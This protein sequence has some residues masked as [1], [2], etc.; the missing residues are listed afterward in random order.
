MDKPRKMQS[1]KYAADAHR[2]T[3]TWHIFTAQ[4]GEVCVLFGRAVQAVMAALRKPSRLYLLLPTPPAIFRP[5][6]GT[7]EVAQ[8]P[9]ELVAYVRKREREGGGGGSRRGQAG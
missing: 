3:A 7:A 9:H 8:T 6:Q 5:S 1:A 2:K 4:K